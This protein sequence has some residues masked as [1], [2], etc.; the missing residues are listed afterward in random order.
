MLIDTGE[1]EGTIVL[2]EVAA[3]YSGTASVAKGKKQN[4]TKNKRKHT[5]QLVTRVKASTSGTSHRCASSR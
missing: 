4:S 3:R 1:L 2:E 5:S